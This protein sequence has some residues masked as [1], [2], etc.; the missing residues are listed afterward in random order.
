MPC[1]RAVPCAC[2]ARRK[3]AAARTHLYVEA[4]GAPRARCLLA[5]RVICGAAAGRNLLLF[6]AAAKRS[7]KPKQ[8][9]FRPNERVGVRTEAQ[10]KERKVLQNKTKV[11][12]ER[13]CKQG[14]KETRGGAPSPPERAFGH[15][16]GAARQG[17]RKATP[18][19][20]STVAR[21][22]RALPLEPES[23]RTCTCKCGRGQEGG[24]ARA[25]AATA[26][27]AAADARQL[28]L[29]PSTCYG[30]GAANRWLAGWLR[31]QCAQQRNGCA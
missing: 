27:R 17:A 3:H 23:G 11:L 14:V 12:L 20:G 30:P 5:R 21:G 13:T 31:R 4:H 9:S 6:A 24:L 26:V 15:R 18:S 7:L 16:R 29:G 1:H 19:I 10:A 28:G 22:A 2:G 8:S 25:P